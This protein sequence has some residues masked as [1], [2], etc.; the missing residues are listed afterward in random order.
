MYLC[1][2]RL[3]HQTSQSVRD[4]DTTAVH[5]FSP[6]PWINDGELQVN[7]KIY[8]PVRS[9]RHYNSIPWW[10][11]QYE[12]IWSGPS[13]VGDTIIVP[14]MQVEPPLVKLRTTVEKHVQNV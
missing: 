9:A 5:N 7:C 6:T 8:L 3:Q 2:I 13:E 1:S 10:L 4:Q 14:T 11:T 12:G